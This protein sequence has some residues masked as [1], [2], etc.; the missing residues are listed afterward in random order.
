MRTAKIND[1]SGVAVTGRC[2]FYGYLVGVDGTNNPTISCYDNKTSAAGTEV[3]PTT[4]YDSSALGLNGFM[5]PGHNPIDCDNGIYIEITLGAGNVEVVVYF[6]GGV[7][8]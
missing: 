6:E 3:V 2:K 1:A 8:A 4:T 5:V 7:G